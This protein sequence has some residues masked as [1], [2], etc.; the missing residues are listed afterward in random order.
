MTDAGAYLDDFLDGHEEELVAFR[1]NIHSHP[2]L[3]RA[4]FQTTSLVAQRLEVAGLTPRVMPQGTGLVCDIGHP[5]TPGPVVALRADLDALAIED[6]KDVPYRSRVAGAAHA[7]GH[8]VHTTVVLGAGLALARLPHALPGRVRLVFQ[9]AEEVV[10]GGAL[11]MIEAGAVAGV[12]TIF[13][14]H[15]DPKIDTGSVGLR[16]GPVTSASDMVTIRLHG[17]GGHTAR[18]HLPANLGDVA[19]RVVTGLPGALGRLTRDPS[20]ANL[21]F[22]AVHAGEVANVIPTT[23]EIKG[24]LRTLDRAIWDA[25]PEVLDDALSAIVE[26]SGAVS[27]MRHRRGSPP[28]V[29]D[30]AATAVMERSALAAL[31]PGRLVEVTQSLG[32]ADF[33]WYLEEVPGA[34]ARLGVHA[35]GSGAALDLHSGAFDVDE[36]AIAVGVRLLTHTALEALR[37]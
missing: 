5:S 20:R 26:G 36:R 25:A 21:V 17:P 13:A 24:T 31:G 18:P 11:D 4:E 22:G 34:F 9:P 10:P 15:C 7:C 3:S 37:R 32:S 33:S 16:A 30:A 23:A 35:P 19:G 6:E 28:I 29:N 27:E 8:D 1:R 12:D 14:L 2:E